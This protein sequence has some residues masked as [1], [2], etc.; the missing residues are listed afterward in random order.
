MT[1]LKVIT[2]EHIIEAALNDD[3]LSIELIAEMGEKLG[4]GVALL[5]NLYNPE[6]I[7]LGG[8]LSAAGD[9]L[10]L[11]MKSSINKYSLS[12]VNNDARLKLTK[13]KEK[14]GV[15]GACLLVQNKILS[16]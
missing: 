3:I 10:I 6:L 15:I 4:R 8:S 2:L 16:E 11:P 5:I 7:I 1:D 13:L 9:Y 14:A 12:I